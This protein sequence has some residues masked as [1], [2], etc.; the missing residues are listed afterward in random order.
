MSARNGG[1]P[2][3]PRIGE[4]FGDP[5][6]DAEGMTL[7]DWFAGQA[8]EEDIEEHAF[9]KLGDGHYPRTREAAKYAYANAMLAARDRDDNA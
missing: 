7:R 2:A 4:G 8:T 3:F 9:V 1:G 5:R 6:Y